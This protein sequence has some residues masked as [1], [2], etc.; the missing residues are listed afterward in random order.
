[1]NIDELKAEVTGD[2]RVYVGGDAQGAWHDKLSDAMQAARRS[3]L[4]RCLEARVVD[5]DTGKTVYEY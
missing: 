5:T 4:A 1:M 2:F 3:G